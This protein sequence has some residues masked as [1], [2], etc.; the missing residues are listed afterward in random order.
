M[1]LY[2]YMWIGIVFSSIIITFVLSWFF[3]SK[4]GK[5]K[6]KE[7]SINAKKICEDAEKEANTIKREKLLEVKDEWYKQKQKFES[8]TK[9]KKNELE[10]LERTLSSKEL[11]LER[12][13]E[14]LNKSERDIKKIEQSVTDRTKN[15]E[16]KEKKLEELMKKELENLEKVSHMTASEAK[17][18]LMDSLID[19]AKRDTALMVKEMLENARLTANREA[20]EIIISAIQRSAVDHAVENTVSVVNLPNED[21]K[22]RIIGRDGRNIRAFE[23]VTGVEVIVDDTPEA[24][25]LSA[26]DPIRREIARMSLENLIEDGRIHPARIEDVVEKTTKEMEDI[27]IEAG[28]QSLVEAGVAKMHPEL[29]KLLGKLKYRTSYGQNVLQHAIE[30]AHLSGLMASSLGLDANIAKRAGLL[31]D[32]GK[33]IDR[34]TEGTHAEIGFDI[35][36]RYKENEI[37]LNAIEAHHEDKDAISPITILV[38]AADSISSSRPGA[39]RANLEGYIR[40]MQNLEQVAESFKGVSKTYA[41]QAGREVRV[42]VEPENVDDLTSFQISQDLAEKIEKEMEYPGQIKVT[43]IREYRAVTYAK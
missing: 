1:G 8:D 20:K 14:L 23:T 28:Q 17:K 25:V 26:F 33:A 31:H 41:I 3:S 11:S 22:G 35:A 2:F 4:I 38:Q 12:K 24:V 30:V 18:I 37:V 7:A 6:I 29:I 43:V 15:I 10:K 36:K 42:I 16:G 32:I 13:A 21:M 9:Q 27:I 5:S 40:R 34:F 39:R 19:K